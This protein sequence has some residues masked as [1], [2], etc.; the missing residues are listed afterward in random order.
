[1]SKSITELNVLQA[2]HG[3]CILVKTFDELK[4]EFVIL[5]DGGTSQ[6][7]KY[8]LKEELKNIPRINLLVL[9]HIDSDHIGGLIS[10]LK[11]SLINKII[12]DEI[13]MNHPEIVEV[14]TGE[15]ISMK[16][17]DDLK[18]L[19]HAKIPGAKMIEISTADKKIK[20][21]GIEFTILS[22]TPE[23]K[24]ELYTQWRSAKLSDKKDITTN[25]SSTVSVYKE[26]LEYLNKLPYRANKSISNDI[27]NSSSISFVLKCLDISILFLADSR[28]EIIEESLRLNGFNELE[29]LIVKYTKISHHGSLN[30]TSQDELGLIQCNNYIISTNGGT[31]THKHPSR[32]TIAR[33]VYS[34]SRT[35][36]PLNIFFNYKL[37]DLK[38]KIGDFINED[39]FNKGNWKVDNKNVF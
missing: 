32:E 5:I 11:S 35:S 4:N 12:V 20:R 28:P 6:T 17:G 25:I 16:Q 22:P 38:N 15:L 3:D 34:K 14:N 31:A 2:Y 19:I 26:S 27:F 7:F 39:D 1:M 9:T 23:I 30:N 13:W 8:S 37:T 21:A 36:E 33:I 18:S 29:P 10:F 24:N